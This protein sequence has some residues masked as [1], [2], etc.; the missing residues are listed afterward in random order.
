MIT[1][2]IAN[3]GHSGC[4]S[5]VFIPGAI[6]VMILIFFVKEVAIKKLA[7][8]TT[9]VGNIQSLVKE[10]KTFVIL[11]IITGIFSLGAFNYSFV[12]L[13]ATDSEL[14]KVLFR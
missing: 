6:A 4:F 10:N 9:I 12:L 5:F 1:C 14:I 2:N 13:I 3:Y 8:T 7:S 11:T